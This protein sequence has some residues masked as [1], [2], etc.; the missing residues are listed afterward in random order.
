MLGQGS[1]NNGPSA[2]R[3]PKRL[4]ALPRNNG[5]CSG[6]QSLGAI[7]EAISEVDAEDTVSDTY[8]FAKGSYIGTSQ[9][10]GNSELYL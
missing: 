7:V 8:V 10:V 3:R 9:L 5:L 2:R 6:E 1:T 4:T